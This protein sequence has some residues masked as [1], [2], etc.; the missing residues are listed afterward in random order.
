M[1]TLAASASTA[2]P[3]RRRQT[4]GYY[5][6]FVYLGLTTAMLGPTLPFL[7]SQVSRPVGDMGY[8]FLASSAGFTAGTVLA[9]R[10]FDR[11]PGHLL[12]ALSQLVSAAMLALIPLAPVFWFLL[13]IAAI[14]GL[15]DGV[16]NTGGNTLLVW[17]HGDQAGPYM[18][19]LHFFFGLGAFLAPFLAAQV[20]N[21]PGGYRW[22]YWMLATVAGLI[23]T[24]LLT[25]RGGPKPHGLSTA[26]GAGEKD[27]PPVLTR[28][29][30]PVV[31][32][33]LLF[34]FFYVGSEIAF[35]GWLYTYATELNLASV[36][37]AAY[38][39][40][41]Y[42]LSFTVGRLLSIPVATRIRPSIIVLAALGGCLAVLAAVIAFP[43]SS[44]VLWIVAVALGFFLAPIYATGFTLAGQ[45]VIL[46]AQVSGVILL[47]DSMGGMILPW[48]VGP[49]IE[50]TGPR[51][52]VYLVFGSL[53]LCAL[54]FI[55][56]L[57]SRP[58]GPK[59]ALIIDFV[60]EQSAG[61]LPSLH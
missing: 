12:L 59:P 11:V 19:A 53:L 60:P 17:T 14:K 28:L 39:T 46:T 26:G 49:V 56:L 21:V 15:A 45:S 2:D 34:L 18:N 44:A 22:A 3:D 7:A 16:I 32:S 8:M 37:A 25:L 57:R 20:I 55:S 30:H 38:L 4:T 36:Q 40:S 13:S 52:L 31:I 10:V 23:G 1:T 5:A 35:G 9:S 33:A 24:R 41:A 54:A 6:L 61:Q 42:W 43:G 58:S 50:R 48:L 47:G 27:K 51:A 29:T